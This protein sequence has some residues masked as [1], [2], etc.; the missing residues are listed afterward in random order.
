MGYEC[1][2]QRGEENSAERIGIDEWLRAV[3]AVPGIRVATEPAVILTGESGE[4]LTLGPG[5]ADVA[6]YFPPGPI[7]RMFGAKGRVAHDLQVPQRPGELSRPHESRLAERCSSTCRRC[8][9]EPPR[10]SHLRR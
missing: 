7:A 2:I 9:R 8:A 1:H 10:G 5:S 4:A 6:V 3:A